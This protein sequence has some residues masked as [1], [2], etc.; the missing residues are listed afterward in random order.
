MLAEV[1]LPHQA[2][3][4]EQEIT[5]WKTELER[6]LP[7]WVGPEVSNEARYYNSELSRHPFS[8]WRDEER[9]PGSDR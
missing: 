7:E 8:E 6:N 9:A 2:V 3:V 4:S 1:E 5:A